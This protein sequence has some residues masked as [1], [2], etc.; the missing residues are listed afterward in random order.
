MFGKVES[1]S[2]KILSLENTGSI[3]IAAKTSVGLYAKNEG[4][5]KTKL[6]VNNTGNINVSEEGSV[7]INGE[8][9]TIEN[10]STGIINITKIKSAGIIA[11][12]ESAITNSGNINLTTATPNVGEGLVGI[13]VD[14]TSTATNDGTITVST[15]N[16]TGI[17]G[18]GGQIT[19]NNKIILNNINS[20]GIS[21]TDGSVFN[22][23]DTNNL[24]EVKNS[25][26]VGIFAKITENAPF[27]FQT[28]FN[29]GTITLNGGNTKTSSVGIYS[30]IE[31]KAVQNNLSQQIANTGT[32]NVGTKGSAGIYVKDNRTSGTNVVSLEV[33][34]F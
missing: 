27:P 2:S 32:I 26:S 7:G 8:K 16:S 1:S 29:K 31:D 11:K 14:N 30:L 19:N 10:G 5:D 33:N 12:S 13:S 17:S 24:I 22:S 4:S 9:S 20:V 23:A 15:K 18:K 25:N 21:S 28:I 6:T 34:F 3:D